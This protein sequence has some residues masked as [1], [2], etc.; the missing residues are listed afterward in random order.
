[1]LPRLE[2]LQVENFAIID[3]IHI[4]LGEGLNVITG[5][6]GAGKTM[7]TRSLDLLLGGKPAKNLIRPGAAA[8]YVEGRFR[9]DPAWAAS[10]NISPEARELL[11]DGAGS[12]TLARRVA[13]EGRS[14]CLVDGRTTSVEVLRELAGCLLRFYGQHEQQKLLLSQAQ[15]QML[16]SS[17]DGR[18]LRLFEAYQQARSQAL[19][20]EAQVQR[21]TAEQRD[22]ARQAELDRF[23]LQE[24]ENLDPQAG[25]EREWEADLRH[26]Q[27]AEQ[28]RLACSQATQL[29]AG[30][31]DQDVDGLLAQALAALTDL[32]DPQVRELS[33][34]MQSMRLD[35][36]DISASLE[37]MADRWEADPERQQ[38]LEQQLGESLRLQRKHSCSHDQLAEL[39]EQLA[40]RVKAADDAPETLKKAQQQAQLTLQVARDAAAALSK[41]R[42]AQAPRLQR[43]VNELLEELAMPQARFEVVLE[44]LGQLQAQGAEAVCFKLAANPG[45]G[46]E[47]LSEVASG[48]ELSRLLLA[49]ISQSQDGHAGTLVLDEPDTGLGG[50]TAHGVAS[51][52]ADLAQRQQVLVVTHLAQIA[53]RAN[54]HVQLFKRVEKKSTHLEVRQLDEEQEILA[55]L[56]RMMGTS[57]SDPAALKAA[58]SLRRA[59]RESESADEP[60]PTS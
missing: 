2:S 50:T 13:S 44:D 6:T 39:R 19:T 55:E 1:M 30:E 52:L 38:W 59:I 17:G 60:L 9:Y 27:Q 31:Q 23:E 57:A 5:E 14:R 18:G 15:A 42:K 36:Q 4:S 25:Q 8:A 24:L 40:A 47:P 10:L 22:S 34:R 28:G 12:L 32:D 33:Q 54:H 53:A 48:G 43:R 35:L 7:L 56:C 45:L 16:D 49:I 29:L 41:W 11:D 20:A 37:D 26:L 58:E 3:S 51:R 46:A 21:I